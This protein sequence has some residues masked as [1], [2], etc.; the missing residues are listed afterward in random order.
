MHW[1]GQTHRWQI[2]G[3]TFDETFRRG[4]GGAL[5]SGIGGRS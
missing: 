4:I 2:Q 5:P 1:R 3:V